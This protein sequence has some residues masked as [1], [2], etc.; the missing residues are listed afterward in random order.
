MKPNVVINLMFTPYAYLECPFY[1]NNQGACLNI[2]GID[3][4]R[5]DL[6]E[7]HNPSCPHFPK[8]FFEDEMMQRAMKRH[9]AYGT[10]CYKASRDLI[11]ITD[12]KFTVKSDKLGSEVR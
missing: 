6:P 5:D 11:P 12:K 8:A 7:G 9:M 2:G 3:L 1:K 10:L 4:Q